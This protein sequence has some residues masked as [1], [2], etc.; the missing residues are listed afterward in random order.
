MNFEVFP[1]GGGV[2]VRLVA[3]AHGA[4]VGLVRGVHVH[5]LL[6]VAGVGK[7]TVTPLH[8]TLER[9]LACNGENQLDIIEWRPGAGRLALS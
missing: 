7:S 4:V 6:P 9:F 2:G 5:M 3:P 8:L 1:E